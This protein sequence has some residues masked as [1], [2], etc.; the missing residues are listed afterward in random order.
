MAKKM[1]DSHLENWKKGIKSAA[2]HNRKILREEIIKLESKIE[3]C[4]RLEGKK[5]A[6]S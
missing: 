3:R 5:A 1:R 6:N 4:C 2:K